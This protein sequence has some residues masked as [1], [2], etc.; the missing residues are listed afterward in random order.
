[1]FAPLHC[2]PAFL[3]ELVKLSHLRPRR[4]PFLLL[5]LLLTQNLPSFLGSVDTVQTAVRACCWC[6]FCLLRFLAKPRAVFLIF[7]SQFR[8][9]RWFLTERSLSVCNVRSAYASIPFPPSALSCLM[10]EP[11]ATICPQQWV[12]WSL[13]FMPSSQLG[14][15]YLTAPGLPPRETPKF[16]SPDQTSL[17]PAVAPPCH[18]LW[19]TILFCSPPLVLLVEEAVPLLTWLEISGTLPFSFSIRVFERR[20]LS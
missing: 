14:F 16:F 9:Y 15:P 4:S 8:R 11:I 18:L 10:A 7:S 19:P 20:G 1:V 17:F 6:D 3:L 12:L 2:F 5:P 13:R